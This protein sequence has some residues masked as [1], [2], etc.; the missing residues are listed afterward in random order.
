MQKL[1]IF[2]IGATVVVLGITG[3]LLGY[4]YVTRDIEDEEVTLQPELI[5]KQKEVEVTPI[6][7][8]K[9]EKIEITPSGETDKPIVIGTDNGL[10]FATITKEKIIQAGFQNP[11]LDTLPFSGLIFKNIDLR[12]YRDDEHLQY[13]LSE[14]TEH[15]GNLTEL[16]FPSKD[17]ADEIYL[18]V[19]SKII[20][21][22]KYEV[23]ETNQYGEK[24]FFAN[25]E[26]DKNSVF[27][28]VK[29]NSRLYT[30][31]YP[32]KNHNKIKNL[33]GLL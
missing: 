16:T 10:P 32:A 31:H 13:K 12:E 19:K 11:D 20:D 14:N 8:E 5:E 21:N 22:G 25:H 3:A 27:L 26:E 29:I 4:K 23:N 18:S 9:E 28:V 17:I 24:S 6:V 7:S 2:F 30:F 15:A 33:I 1:T